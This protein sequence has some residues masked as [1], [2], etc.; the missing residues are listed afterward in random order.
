M[1][2][3][4]QRQPGGMVAMLKGEREDVLELAAELGLSLAN[5]NAP[6]QIVL[7]GP[8]ELVDEAVARADGIGCRGAQAR[9]RR[10]LPLAAHGARRGR[11]SR[12]RSTRRPSARPPSPC[13]PTAAPSRS[14]TCGASLPRTSSS[15]CAG[16][17]RCS[18]CR[19]MGAT[20]FVECGPGAVLQ[21][22]RQAHAAG[23]RVKAGVFG[24]G[25]ALPE[26][27]VTNADLVRDLDT[28]DEWIVRRTG[29]RERRHLNGTRTL[30]D[31]AAEACVVALQDAGRDA[32]EV[33]HVM[34]CASRPIA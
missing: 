1:A 12:R 3:A 33:D 23:G 34:V 30:A 27:I 6:G 4:A 31:L 19:R 16:A 25:A 10:R 26:E 32:A 18:P 24:I 15:P 21:R 20:D 9:R 29:I 28:T 14:S 5:D 17:R 13:S 8:M 22:P 2:D 11:A 7:S